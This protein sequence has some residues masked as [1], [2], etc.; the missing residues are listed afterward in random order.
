LV[1]VLP[2]FADISG[3]KAREDIDG[4]SVLPSLL[5]QPQDLKDRALY[6]AWGGRKLIGPVGTPNAWGDDIFIQ[7]VRQGHWKA[8]RFDNS[9]TVELYDLDIDPGEQYNIAADH[10]KI[11]ELLKGIMKREHHPA[12][13]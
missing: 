7:A 6:W 11:A 5:G 9:D 8:V 13:P 2:T 3:S 12:T 10:P 4:I 1:D